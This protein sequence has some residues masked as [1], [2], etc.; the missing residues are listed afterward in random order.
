M[1]RKRKAAKKANKA[2]VAKTRVLRKRLTS[3][4]ANANKAQAAARKGAARQIRVLRVRQAV[5][6]KALAKL[7]RQGAAASGPILGGLQK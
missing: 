4:I 2:S 3:L 1:A 7:G 6:R 5:A